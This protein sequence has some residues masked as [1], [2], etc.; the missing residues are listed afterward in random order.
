M[1]V[2]F[3]G[4][5]FSGVLGNGVDIC[6]FAYVTMKYNLSEKVATPT[7]VLLMAYNAWIGNLI[8]FFVLRDVQPAVVEYW[9][10]CI[11]VVMLGAPLGAF[12]MTRVPRLAIAVMLYVIIVVQFVGAVLIIQPAGLLAV[13]S[14]LVFAVGMVLF[15]GLTLSKKGKDTEGSIDQTG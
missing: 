8:H 7:S 3:V 15:F 12:V 5:C 13:W 4:G 6:T 1:I 10:V 14:A 9:L 11:P 2:G